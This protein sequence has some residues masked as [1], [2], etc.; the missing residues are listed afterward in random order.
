MRGGVGGPL[1]GPGGR[2]WGMG[3]LWG[4][5]RSPWAILAGG[6]LEVPWGPR[7]APVDTRGLGRES[8]GGPCGVIVGRMKTLKKHLSLCFDHLE[9][10]GG[11]WGV[12]VVPSGCLGVS[13]DPW[14]ILGHRRGL[15]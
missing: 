4:S 8:S 13:G 15:P 2:H 11:T 1:G 7:D 6:V 12:L 9:I 10:L 5:L 3:A 14:E